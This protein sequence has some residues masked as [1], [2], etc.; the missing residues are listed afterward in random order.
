MKPEKLRIEG[1]F[2]KNGSIDDIN[3]LSRQMMKK[4]YDVLFLMED[5]HPACALIKGFF[6]DLK[7]PIFSYENYQQIL[8]TNIEEYST[9]AKPILKNMP[10]L[11]YKVLLLTLGF[12]LYRVVS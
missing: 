6:N 2:R 1:I 10:I 12:L 11:N 9:L 5:P 3:L 4:S 7:E 8:S